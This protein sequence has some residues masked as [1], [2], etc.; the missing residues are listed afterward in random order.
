MQSSAIHADKFYACRRVKMCIF[1][2]LAAISTTWHDKRQNPLN[3]HVQLSLKSRMSWAC[4]VRLNLAFLLYNRS[5]SVEQLFR[6]FRK[7]II[8]GTGTSKVVAEVYVRKHQHS[9]RD[10]RCVL[11]QLQLLHAR[12]FVANWKFNFKKESDR[13]RQTD[14]V[15]CCRVFI[16][17]NRYLY[18][19]QRHAA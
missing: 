10:H 19:R 1:E 18:V 15:A 9:A 7:H 11:H 13:D 14:G 4:K 3:V 2:S 8:K 6:N 17:R 16:M 12:R 5:D